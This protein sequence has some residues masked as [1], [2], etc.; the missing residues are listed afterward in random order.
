MKKMTA[1]LVAALVLYGSVGTV[2]AADKFSAGNREPVQMLGD[3]M[4]KFPG[5]HLK[6][7]FSLRGIQADTFALIGT[8][9]ARLD[10]FD[11]MGKID[12]LLRNNQPKVAVVSLGANDR[13]DIRAV[14]GVLSV[15]TPEWTAEYAARIGNVMDRLVA[16]GVKH[17]IWLK[18]PP[19][20]D[21]PMQT[22]SD[23]I[24][25]TVAEQAATRPQ[26]IIYDFSKLITN[27]KGGYTETV[28]D[29]RT[30]KAIKVR[31]SDGIHLTAESA[32]ML[33]V[34]LVDTYW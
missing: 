34:D 23:Q 1:F 2:L 21:A 27:P 32:R 25:R 6:R 13:Q 31:D 22:F 7:Q 10:M 19:M 18:L 11:W 30:H 12:E 17:I 9:V 33:S 16:G 28:M 24:N 5:E 29:R 26:V 14:N 15:G 3:S 4:M 20:R 8:G